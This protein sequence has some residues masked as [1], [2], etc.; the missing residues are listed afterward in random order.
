MARCAQLRHSVA[1]ARCPATPC[2]GSPTIPRHASSGTVF[3]PI[4]QI[5]MARFQ[6]RTEGRITMA[7]HMD[8]HG[9][10]D[11]G[12]VRKSNEDQFLIA[13]LRKAMHVYQRCPVKSYKVR[14]LDAHGEVLSERYLEANSYDS[15]LRQLDS[16]AEGAHQ[17]EVYNQGGGAAGQIDVGFWRQRVRRR[18]SRRSIVFDTPR[19][20]KYHGRPTN[21][22]RLCVGLL[23]E[24][25]VR[26]L[27]I[28]SGGRHGVLGQRTH[29]TTASN[30]SRIPQATTTRLRP[31]AVSRHGK[32]ASMSSS[33]CDEL[34][35][36]ERA[37]P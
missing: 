17:I 2:R 22:C 20:E 10:T 34:G 13:D 37:N 28:G 15:V 7:I 33:T 27:L 21:M 14:Q 29:A 4:D 5:E 32:W 35:P 18:S 6:S 19:E 36:R 1:S 11:I 26:L 23:P 12:R 25:N 31:I 9:M 30:G 16:V 24:W 8:C 3:A